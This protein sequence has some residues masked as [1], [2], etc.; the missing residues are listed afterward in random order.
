MS[1]QIQIVRQALIVSF[2]RII[3]IFLGNLSVLKLMD[4]IITTKIAKIVIKSEIMETSANK[5]NDAIMVN[6][7]FTFV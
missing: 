6:I 1:R 4:P 7:L 5:K 2:I 3:I